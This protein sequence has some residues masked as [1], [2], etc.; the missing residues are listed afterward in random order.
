[1]HARMAGIKIWRQDHVDTVNWFLINCE[2]VAP[3]I[4]LNTHQL[5]EKMCPRNVVGRA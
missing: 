4:V 3:G 1:M 2:T 5:R